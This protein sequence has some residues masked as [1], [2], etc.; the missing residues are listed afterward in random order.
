MTELTNEEQNKRYNIETNIY[1]LN[2]LAGR[3]SRDCIQTNDAQNLVSEYR[4]EI[5]KLR[6]SLI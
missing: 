2:E 6:K 4:A 5:D 1:F 3:T